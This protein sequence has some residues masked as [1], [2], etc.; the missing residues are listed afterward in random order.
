METKGTTNEANLPEKGVQDI[1]S[2][3]V[4]NEMKTELVN[5]NVENSEIKEESDPQI[6]DKTKE[7]VNSDKTESLE[8]DEDSEEEEDNSA[9]SIKFISTKFVTSSPSF[10]TTP[11]PIF[12]GSLFLL[13]T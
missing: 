4:N 10:R 8:I 9:P 6:E 2:E 5:E 7:E 13:Y 3:S 11:V 12:T 1:N